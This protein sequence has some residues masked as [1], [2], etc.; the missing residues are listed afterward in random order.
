MSSLDYSGF[1]APLLWR[2]EA[3]YDGFVLG[4]QHGVT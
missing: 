4:T 1:R 2:R 3:F